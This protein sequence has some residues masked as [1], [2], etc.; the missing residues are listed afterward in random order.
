MAILAVVCGSLLIVYGYA[1]MKERLLLYRVR[2]T[3][4]Q[5]TCTILEKEIR[6]NVVTRISRHFRGSHT[7]RGT[8]QVVVYLP[9]LQY[10]YSVDGREHLGLAVSPVTKPEADRALV[11]KVIARYEVGRDYSCWRDPGHPDQV[12]LERP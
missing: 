8:K 9:H 11:E 10:R 7:H 4:V 12:F 3:Y 6:T 1:A 5:A 2:H